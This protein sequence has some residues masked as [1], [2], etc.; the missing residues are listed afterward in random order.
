MGHAERPDHRPHVRP[1]SALGRS[2]VRIVRRK[3]AAF[4]HRPAAPQRRRQA[5]GGVA[6]ERF[7]A[8]ATQIEIRHL[9]LESN[10]QAHL[11]LIEETAR[12]GCQLVVFPVLSVTGHNNSPDVVQLAE[13]ADGRI[14]RTLQA[15]A[16]A[17]GIIVG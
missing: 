8:A 10:L 1:L 17:S 12:A 4:C 13:E 5:G 15:Q 9:D 11:Q 2:H 7:T 6:L 16:K 3:P 14:F